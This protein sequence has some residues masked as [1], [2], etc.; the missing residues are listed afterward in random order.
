MEE[1]EN[2]VIVLE[3]CS[4]QHQIFQS[5]LDCLPENDRKVLH[6]IS[7]FLLAVIDMLL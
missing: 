4:S 7:Q 6:M 1:R 3:T 5:F 2:E